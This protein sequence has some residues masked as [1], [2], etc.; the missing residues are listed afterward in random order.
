MSGERLFYFKKL[1][2]AWC[3]FVL[4][5]G[6]TCQIAQPS[7]KEAKIVFVVAWFDV[8]KEALERLPGVTRVEKGFSGSREI[9]TV[10]YDPSK[11]TVEEMEKALKQAKTYR[12]TVRA[13]Q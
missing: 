4:F 7:E 5:Y 9:N 11:V 8:G 3:L 1:A 13:K 2:V 6:I 10:F 12:E